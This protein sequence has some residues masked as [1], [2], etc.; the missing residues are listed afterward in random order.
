MTGLLTMAVT[1]KSASFV[2]DN[3]KDRGL[4]SRKSVHRARRGAKLERTCRLEYRTKCTNIG[5]YD[6]QITN[7]II[8]DRN[9]NTQIN[10]TV[11]D[12]GNM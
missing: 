10:F 7:N 2:V 6:Y 4:V 3:I 1:R 8:R 9:N 5:S 11:L 12:I